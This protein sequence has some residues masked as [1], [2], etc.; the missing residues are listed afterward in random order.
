M[1]TVGLY[2]GVLYNLDYMVEIVMLHCGE[3][4]VI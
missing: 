3:C 4:W 1:E 2:G